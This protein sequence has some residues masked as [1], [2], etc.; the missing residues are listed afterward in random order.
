VELIFLSS[1]LTLNFVVF[2]SNCVKNLAW[3]FLTLLQESLDILL[4]VPPTPTLP[5]KEKNIALFLF[6]FYRKLW[7]RLNGQHAEALSSWQW[8]KS[9]RKF[10]K[11]KREV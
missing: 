8:Q 3:I 7:A 5:S 9:G 2:Q 10:H 11:T 4:P 1:I 6:V